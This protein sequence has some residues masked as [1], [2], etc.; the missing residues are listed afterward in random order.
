MLCKRGPMCRYLG[1]VK[2]SSSGNTKSQATALLYGL[3]LLDTFPL[4]QGKVIKSSWPNHLLDR[5]NYEQMQ[6][7]GC[8]DL[9]LEFLEH[10]VVF[11]TQVDGLVSRDTSPVHM[12]RSLLIKTTF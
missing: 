7:T 3:Q 11:S 1:F 8:E 6:N 12:H 9:T 10:V 2:T 4:I 5:L